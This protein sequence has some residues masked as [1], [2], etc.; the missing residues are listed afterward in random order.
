MSRRTI[1]NIAMAVGI[2]VALIGVWTFF[3]HVKGKR[4]IDVAG[5]QVVS[6][7]LDCGTISHPETTAKVKTGVFSTGAIPISALDRLQFDDECDS[8]RQ[9]KSVVA[10]ALFFGGLLVVLVGY[11]Y[12]RRSRPAAPG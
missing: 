7:T 11:G 12:R 2:V 6:V 4:A 9:T 1:A 3:D 8:A 10:A 5:L